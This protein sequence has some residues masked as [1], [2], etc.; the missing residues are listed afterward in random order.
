MDRT[1]L[2][3][4]LRTTRKNKHYRQQDIAR[5]GGVTQ[6]ELSN[7]ENK[8]V[9][10]RLSTLKQIADALDLKIIALPKERL[11]DVEKLLTPI[12]EELQEDNHSALLEKYRVSDE[13]E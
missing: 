8:R 13:D 5:W 10:I 12:T 11:E 6:S 2:I 4:I 9:D 3:S 1:D 7:I